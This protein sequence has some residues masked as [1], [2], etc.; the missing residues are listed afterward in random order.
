MMPAAYDTV[1]T[2]LNAA[3]V[4]LND[5]IESLSPNTG[6][7]LDN[8]SAF[9]QE[10]F[11]LA[12]RRFQEQLGTLG[13]VRLVQEKIVTGLPIV[14]S[15]DP[16]SQ[17]F[18]SWLGCSD[19]VNTFPTPSLPANLM[20]P[21]KCWERWTAQNAYFSDPPMENVMDGLPTWQK[22]P[23]NRMW[24]WREDSIWMPGST[25]S[26]DLRIRFAA[27]LPD[28]DDV[29]SEPW[30][31]Q[32]VPIA[33]CVDPLAWYLAAEVFTARQQFDLMAAAVSKAEYATNQVMNRDIRMKQRVNVVRKPLSGRYLAGSPWY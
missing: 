25:M 23:C 29:G 13:A 14:A 3:R 9:T 24:E 16:A 8:S 7:I 21:L 18:V 22:Q 4:R 27:Y 17:V 10:L 12:Y 6:K 32:P 11:N 31:T 15:S 1:N 2:I 26:M 28:I 20:F 30:F 5:T 19:G 33:R